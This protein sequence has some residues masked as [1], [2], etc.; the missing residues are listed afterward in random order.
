MEKGS[1]PANLFFSLGKRNSL[2]KALSRAPS[3]ILLATF[4]SPVRVSAI[5]GQEKRFADTD[6]LVGHVCSFPGARLMVTLNEMGGLLEK[7]K[8][9]VVRR[10]PPHR[11]APWGPRVSPPVAVLPH[12]A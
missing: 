9:N 6:I 2:L 5:V 11:D 4:E 7:K 12:L 8:K 1:L 3:Y 10:Q